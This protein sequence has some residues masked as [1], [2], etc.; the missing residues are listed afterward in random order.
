MSVTDIPILRKQL[1]TLLY[2]NQRR[3]QRLEELQT[4]CSDLRRTTRTAGLFRTY[5][6]DTT[7][8][9]PLELALIAKVEDLHTQIAVV[10]ERQ[11]IADQLHLTIQ[12]KREEIC[13]SL[14]VLRERT[15]ELNL[16]YR[17]VLKHY[18]DMIVAQYVATTHETLANN[19]IFRTKLKD[20]AVRRENAETL[21]EHQI[22]KESN[23][24]RTVA[25]QSLVQQRKKQ[26]SD[27]ESRRKDF[28]QRLQQEVENAAKRK[29]SATVYAQKIEE[30][31][32]HFRRISE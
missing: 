9:S 32:I 26:I 12:R 5:S 24:R 13:A 23:E 4:T 19:L 16:A 21:A 7:S 15:S 8:A 11:T 20:E 6:P 2:S 1:D 31:N 18:H 25:A 17:N 10:E 27:L 29:E 28:F 30:F 22:V 3:E 14:Y